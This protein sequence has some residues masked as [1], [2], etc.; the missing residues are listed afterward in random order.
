MV[1]AGGGGLEKET[2]AFGN[3][4]LVAGRLAYL[5]PLRVQAVEAFQGGEGAGEGS[6]GR[7]QFLERVALETGE[8]GLA[9]LPASP[10]LLPVPQG[11][12]AQAA[13]ETGREEHHAVLAAQGEEVV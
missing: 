5:E 4:D 10:Q 8:E 13:P 2:L 11:A 3:M 12:V 9:D 6:Q 7:P 1:R